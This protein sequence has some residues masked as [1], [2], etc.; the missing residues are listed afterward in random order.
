VAP[1]RRLTLPIVVRVLVALSLVP[2]LLGTWAALEQ[3]RR[4]GGWTPVPAE[5]VRAEAVVRRTRGGS[6][7]RIEIRYRY[8]AG[9]ATREADRLYPG[10]LASGSGDRALLARFPVGARVTARHDP[11]DP[12]RAFLLPEPGFLPYLLFLAG[13]PLAALAAGVATGGVRFVHSRERDVPPPRDARDDWWEVEVFRPWLALRDSSAAALA[14]FGVFGI[15]AFGHFLAVAPSPGALAVLV[16]LGWLAL[17]GRLAWAVVKRTLV[18][19]TVREARVTVRPVVPVPGEAFHVR[20]EQAVRGETRVRALEASLVAERTELRR[21]GTRQ[22][23]VFRE[24]AMLLRDTPASPM[25]P[26]RGEHAFPVP[27]APLHE[28]GIVRWRVEVRTR[29]LGPDYRT[30]FP[31]AEPDE[32]QE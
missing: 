30:R 20:V 26:L 5:I 13:A 4:I 9:G 22:K 16:L 28:G 18:A 1:A 24:T 6:E 15:L 31:L 14:V 12:A 17:L 10:P 23:V 29:L 7:T 2:T 21:R 25:R 19:R 32:E 11:R 27:P 8:A 3:A